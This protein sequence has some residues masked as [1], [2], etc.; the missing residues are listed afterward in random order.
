MVVG[1]GNEEMCFSGED[2]KAEVVFRQGVEQIESGSFGS[3]QAGRG[4]VSG[5]HGAG[6]VDGKH[7]IMAFVY[8]GDFSCS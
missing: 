2:D 6:D 4:D 5:E 3:F 8:G 7:D 1:Q